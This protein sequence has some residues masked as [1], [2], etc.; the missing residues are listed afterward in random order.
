MRHILRQ[1]SLTVAAVGLCTACAMGPQGR[2]T[3][4]HNPGDAKIVQD[5]IEC[6]ALASQG[7]QGYGA[8]FS[9][10][11]LREGLYAEQK[12]QLYNLCAQSRGYSFQV[13]R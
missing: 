7:A 9:D 1:L 13:E 3:A 4:P 12:Q 11:M 6:L 5:H 10:R 2:W 8:F